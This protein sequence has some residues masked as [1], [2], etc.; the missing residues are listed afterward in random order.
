MVFVMNGGGRFHRRHLLAE[1]RRHL[2]L[3]LRGRR[4]EPGLDELI[5]QAALATYCTDSRAARSSILVGHTTA[6]AHAAV[7]VSQPRIVHRLGLPA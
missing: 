4:R 6:A 3:V 2:A 7:A 5:V 1:A